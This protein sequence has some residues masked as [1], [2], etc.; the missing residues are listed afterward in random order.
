MKKTLFVLVLAIVLALSFST[1][2]MAKYAGY[3]YNNPVVVF[4]DGTTETTT[5]ANPLP[6]YL[7]WTGALTLAPDQTGPHGDYT[8]T[9]VKCAVCHSV[10]RAASDRT[11]AGVGSHWDLTPAGQSCI[12]CH[13]AS[14]ANPTGRL[15]EWPSTYSLGGPHSRQNCMGAC[16]SGVHG[17]KT[18][19][20][21]AAAAFL[22]NPVLDAGLTAAIDTG[23]VKPGV[24]D[25]TTLD[26]VYSTLTSTQKAGN[27]AMVTGYLC[28]QSGCH[29]SSQFA[30]NTWGYAGMRS[31]YPSSSTATDIAFTGHSTAYAQHCGSGGCHNV[32]L[33]SSDSN[34]ATCHDM[35]GVATNS[36]AWPHANRNISVYEW[37]RPDGVFT[38]TTK[39][40][41]AGN[42][43]MYG[44]DATYRDA[45]GEPTAT[46]MWD[47][48]A[49]GGGTINGY[50]G[51]RVNTRTVIE[52]AVGF[53]DGHLGNINDSVCLKCHGYAYWPTHG[54]IASTTDPLNSHYPRNFA[55]Y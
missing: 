12:A 10:H 46:A 20:Y 21:S 47:G 27:R 53:H 16:H 7:S 38:Q 43:W 22:L 17:F 3:A 40:V 36:T 34:C 39:D 45:S 19:T 26:G 25:A 6:G 51:T 35:V 14:G 49:V 9:T 44:G 54:T 31:A 11:T 42:L 18:S 33:N 2:A 48:V 24:V 41:V 1:V 8:A 23:N 13:T 52:G 55:N 28:A 30:V 50:S 4:V 29:G 5:V 32:A 37:T 15:V